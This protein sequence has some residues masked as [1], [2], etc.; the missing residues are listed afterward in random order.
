MEKAT[1][2]PFAAVGTASV[3]DALAEHDLTGVIEGP[4]FVVGSGM[5]LGRA[6]TVQLD[7]AGQA[8]PEDSRRIWDVVDNAAAGSVLVVSTRGA[9]ISALGGVIAGTAAARDFAGAVTDGLIRDADE[10]ASH[11]FPV[12]CRRAHPRAIWGCCTGT[13]IPVR[14]G[15]VEVAAG[16]LIVADRD[17]VVCVPKGIVT[18]VMERAYRIEKLERLWVDHARAYRSIAKGFEA[19]TDQY[20]SP[21]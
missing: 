15:D 7:A 3:A 20:G 21:H 5:F 9:E 14:F 10:I 8:G 19:V 6:V 18:D 4:Q 2:T 1:G 16:D 17:G 13:E 12:H 11:G